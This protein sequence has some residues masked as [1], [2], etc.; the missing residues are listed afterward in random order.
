MPSNIKIN[1]SDTY[2]LM[3][4]IRDIPPE[5]MFFRDRYFP[6]GAGDMFKEKKVPVS[7]K[8]GDLDM[9]PFVSRRLGP[10]EIERDG[11]EIREFE[12]A[13]ISVQ[14]T[15]KP[16]DLDVPMF[17]ENFFAHEDEA[18]RAIDLAAEDMRWLD[19]MISRREEWLSVQTM[20]NNACTIQE[21]VDSKT[22]GQKNFL[23][24]YRTNENEHRFT[25]SK[26]WS[27]ADADIENDVA[28]M[29]QMVADHNGDPQDLVVGPAVWRVMRN[30][31][32]IMKTLDKTLDFNHNAI[33]EKYIKHGVLFAG[34]LLFGGYTLNVF[35]VSTKYTDESKT[36]QSYFPEDGALVS[37]PAC[38]RM[39]YGSVVQQPFG[40]VHYKKFTAKRIPK[41]INKNEADQNAFVLKSAPL[42][43][44]R[45][46][47]PFAFAPNVLGASAS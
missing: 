23:A 42:A 14:R 32:T 19:V 8:D 18:K 12:P 38:G 6:T 25:V 46:Y 36:L 16:D 15:I 33:N 28:E 11:F 37:F 20:L 21:Y 24:F 44:P 4:L 9:A 40:S 27:S 3:R 5:A 22:M 31:S 29:C 30:N 7:F 2:T 39:M 34:K 47:C 1:F 43:M 26:P 13:F 17:G 45:T 10:I 35:V 41:F